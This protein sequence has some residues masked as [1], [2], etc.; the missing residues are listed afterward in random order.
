[1][2]PQNRGNTVSSCS[3]LHYDFGCIANCRKLI[4]RSRHCEGDSLKQSRKIE[5]LDCFT[6]RVRNDEATI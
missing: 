1:M 5:I 6:L 3:T 2:Y 4:N